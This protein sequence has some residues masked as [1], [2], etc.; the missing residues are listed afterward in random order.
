M[1]AWLSRARG[2]L[3]VACAGVIGV[4]Q[5]LPVLLIPMDWA[6]WFPAALAVLAMTTAALQLLAHARGFGGGWV[7]WVIGAGIAGVVFLGA[8]CIAFGE[9]MSHQRMMM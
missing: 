5:G 2:F 7:P 9:F 1:T 8:L 4:T 6:A 3:W